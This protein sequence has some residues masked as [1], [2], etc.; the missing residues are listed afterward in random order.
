MATGAGRRA[1]SRG[2]LA[3]RRR[4]RGGR[5]RGRSRCAARCSSSRSRF[6]ER[7][8]A[9]R[10]DGDRGRRR[11]GSARA[12]ARASVD[13]HEEARASADAVLPQ[14]ARCSARHARVDSSPVRVRGVLRWDAG[15]RGVVRRRRRRLGG[16]RHA[17]RRPGGSGARRRGRASWP[18]WPPRSGSGTR[19]TGDPRPGEALRGVV[20]TG[21]RPR[22]PHDEARRRGLSPGSI[23]TRARVRRRIDATFD[24]RRRADGASARARR[25][26]PGAGR[27]PTPSGRAAF[28]TSS[29]SRG[30]ISCSSSRSAVRVLEGRSGG[31]SASRRGR[32]GALRGRGR[33]PRRVALRRVR[34]RRRLHA[35]GRVDGD[36]RPRGAR[37]RTARR[38]DAGVRALG[39]RHGAAEPAD[40]VRPLLRALCGS[41]RGAPRVRAAARRAVSSVARL[42]LRAARRRS[43]ALGDDPRRVGPVR[44]D[45]RALRADASDRRRRREPAGGAARRVGRAA[46]VPRPRPPAS[47]PS[48]ERGCAVGRLRRALSRPGHRAGVRVA[49]ARRRRS[50]NR[51]RGS[52]WR[53]SR[54]LSR[55]SRSARQAAALVVALALAVAGRARARARRRAGAPRGLLRATFLDVGQGD[56]A[57]LDLPDGAGARRRRRGARRQSDRR[58]RP[59][60]RA[61]ASRAPTRRALAA[62]VLTHPHPDHF[63]GL[64]TGLDGV[65][66]R[67]RSGTRGRASK[68]RSAEATRRCSRAC[69]RA[70]VPDPPAGRALRILGSSEGRGSKCSRRA[71]RRRR[72]GTRTTTR[73]CSASPTARARCLLVGDAQR[74][75]EGDLLSLA[76]GDGRVGPTF[77]RSVIMA[78]PRRRRPHS[79]RPSRPVEADRLGRA[80]GI[81]SATPTR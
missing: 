28:R 22:R 6:A 73:S 23:D 1:P 30:C 10:G 53:F 7:A 71:Q 45:S 20:R 15:S 19:A 78:A 33:D 50:R 16:P 14:P 31:S 59:R 69:A 34:R 41:H 12:R 54:S 63:G 26:R 65:D 61:G 56:A 74:E 79:W 32:R 42:H 27:R 35:A 70:R 77:S 18:R 67:R 49:V 5:A 64:V 4:T 8:S 39:R 21:G 40:R 48:A 9:H 29:R 2:R 57:I 80:H 62:A 75:E 72:I 76:P 60:P 38:C 51:R 44:A 17:L 25:E 81:A 58:R 11:S 66:R 43:R 37:A 24:A 52:S 47:W 46:A 13:R 3:C 68:S 55:P 36:G